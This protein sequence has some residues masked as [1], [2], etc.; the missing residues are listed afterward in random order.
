VLSHWLQ[1]AIFEPSDKCLT[2]LRMNYVAGSGVG[3]NDGYEVV[4][5]AQNQLGDLEYYVECDFKGYRYRHY[6]YTEKNYPIRAKICR[7]RVARWTPPLKAAASFT[8]VRPLSS[9]Y[10]AVSVVTGRITMR[11]D[12][13]DGRVS[14]RCVGR[15]DPRANGARRT[16]SSISGETANMSPAVTVS[17]PTRSTGSSPRRR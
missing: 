5:P 17:I 3:D 9:P 16:C 11:T 8:R 12:P 7:S 1:M 6:D 2:S 14:Q 15:H 4:V 10:G 13:H